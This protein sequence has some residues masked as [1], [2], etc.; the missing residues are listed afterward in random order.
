M[1]KWEMGR[2]AVEPSN[3]LARKEQI[4]E[5]EPKEQAEKLALEKDGEPPLEQQQLRKL[6]QELHRGTP[7]EKQQLK[8]PA[9]DQHGELTQ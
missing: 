7:Q 2:L 4:G 9:M 5:T 8:K 1:S 6:A 3:G